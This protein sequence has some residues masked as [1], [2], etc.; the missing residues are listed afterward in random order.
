MLN[1]APFHTVQ[2]S[3]ISTLAAY[4]PIIISVSIVL[5]TGSRSSRFLPTQICIYTI[6][7]GISF[8]FFCQW[9]EIKQNKSK[10]EKYSE[11]FQS[12][13]SCGD[14]IQLSACECIWIVLLSM[15]LCSWRYMLAVW[16]FLNRFCALD[17]IDFQVW[18]R[19]GE[20]WNRFAMKL[21]Q[22]PKIDDTNRCPFKGCS[23]RESRTEMLFLNL[24]C[25][26]WRVNS[27]N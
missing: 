27:S 26:H 24:S 5:K 9:Y 21:H 13:R 19:S 18:T 25:M 12:D 22:T 7:I 16:L 17:R 3:V 2:W 23:N 14:G 6:H 10:L 15:R 20:M 8:W 11:G 4:L 1:F